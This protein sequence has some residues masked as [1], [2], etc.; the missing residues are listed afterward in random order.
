MHEE[1]KTV[2]QSIALSPRPSQFFNVKY[3]EKGGVKCIIIVWYVHVYS[4]IV[5]AHV[6]YDTDKIKIMGLH[7][8]QTI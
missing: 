6:T 8:T 2:K 3:M 7:I 1:T 4:R 5:E